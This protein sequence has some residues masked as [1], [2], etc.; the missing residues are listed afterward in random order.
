MREAASFHPAWAVQERRPPQPATA[1]CWPA[2]PLQASV[3]F[4]Q[5][6]HGLDLDQLLR[7][8]I[9]EHGSLIAFRG[10]PLTYCGRA[11]SAAL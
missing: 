7:Q 2:P 3:D 4:M 11:P 5:R 9:T 6:E 10:G 8:C 1:A